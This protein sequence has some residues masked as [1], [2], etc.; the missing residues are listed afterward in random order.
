M[1]KWTWM[2]RQPDNEIKTKRH[3]GRSERKRLTLGGNEGE[4]K[5]DGQKKREKQERSKERQIYTERSSEGLT[6]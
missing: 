2:E 1:E 4:R 3:H 5:R 6:H